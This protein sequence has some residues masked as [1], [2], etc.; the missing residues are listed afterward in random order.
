MPESNLARIPAE[1]DWIEA[2]A[3]PEAFITAHDA[4]FTRGHLQMGERV[5]IHAAGF[6]RRHGRG[7]T[8]ARRG[9][10]GLRHLAHDGQTRAS[11]RIEPGNG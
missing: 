3:M 7:A 5:L 9:C 8:G 4:L 10:D 11:A 2:G 6:R 1:L